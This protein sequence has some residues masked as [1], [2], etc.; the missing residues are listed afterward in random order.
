[1][2]STH[3]FCELDIFESRGRKHFSVDPNTGKITKTFMKKCFFNE[4][5]TRHILPNILV[6]LSMQKKKNVNKIHELEFKIR[7]LPLTLSV[8]QC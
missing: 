8:Y 7:R 2:H 3:S 6:K 4:D 5:I 1:M